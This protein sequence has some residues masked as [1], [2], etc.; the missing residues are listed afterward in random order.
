MQN[1]E[2]I[3]SFYEITQLRDFCNDC[4][5]EDRRIYEER[6]KNA[7]YMPEDNKSEPIKETNPPSYQISNNTYNTN[8]KYENN[9]GG[10][11]TQY[12]YQGNETGYKISNNNYNYNNNMQYNYYSQMNPN[13][14]KNRVKMFEQ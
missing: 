12:N 4:A 8:Y 11:E 13:T 3:F 2:G 9:N 10:S 14:F 7:S 5:K 6:K 1:K